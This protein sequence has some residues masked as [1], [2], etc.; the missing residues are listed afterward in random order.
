MLLKGITSFF[1]LKIKYKDNRVARKSLIGCAKKMPCP[2]VKDNDKQRIQ[3][4]IGGGPQP[5]HAHPHNRLAGNTDK[6]TKQ[7]GQPLEEASASHDPI[8]GT[9]IGISGLGNAKHP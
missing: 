5:G 3:N 1:S 6:I 4:N 2:P 7:L 9:G 8:I